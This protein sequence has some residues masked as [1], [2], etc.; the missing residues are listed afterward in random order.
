MPEPKPPL[1]DAHAH[2]DFDDFRGETDAVL[3]RAHDAGLVGLVN[4]GAGRGLDGL[5][6]AVALAAR[7]PDVWAA[8]GV[9]PHD[10]R[11]LDDDA[12]DRVRD[13]ARRPRVVAIGE[14]GLDYHYDHSP[15]PVQRAAFAAQLRLARELK[16]P[17]VVHTREAEDDTIAVLVDEGAAEVGGL[18]HCFSGG[19]RLARVGLSLGLRIS[20]SG[21]LTFPRADALRDVARR[22][23]PIE[24]SLV[25]TDA[26]FLAPVPFRGKR[27]EPAFVVHTAAKLAEVH[28]LSLEDVARITTRSARSVYRLEDPLEPRLAYPIRDSLYLNI[29]NRCTLAC[30]FCPKRGDWMVKGHYLKLPDE[31]SGAELR[32]ASAE[33][34]SH[35]AFREVVFC[36]FGES[37]LRLDLLMTLAREFRAK[38]L[39][40]RLDTDGLASLVHGRDVV[41]E[42]AGVLDEVSVSLNAPDAAAHARI[43]PSRFGTRA[44]PAVVEFLRSAKRHI[45]TVT[46]SV[47]A[48]PGLDV[49]ACRRLAEDDLGVRFRVREYN[50]VG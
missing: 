45:G 32:A 19:E 50:V 46:A 20:F 2:L 9:H 12:L 37:T 39:H 29:T 40:I 1:F 25:E 17:I 6:A 36:G 21:V 48:V 23:V 15:R 41:P 34:L 42:L 38:G 7:H 22:V 18:L 10:A 30:T 44:W 13:L 49:E 47:V 24:K 11:L 14:I 43:C 16:L 8:V 5:A 31:P 3:A 35:R 4:V 33:E 27:C 28:G 26:P